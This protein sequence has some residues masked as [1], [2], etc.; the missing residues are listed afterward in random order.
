MT[1]HIGPVGPEHAGEIMT[2]QRAA[3]L[4]E[5]QAHDVLDLPPL[6]ETLDQIKASLEL[7]FGAWLGPRLVGSIRGRVE[8]TRMQ[9]A[10]LS[11]APDMQ[12]QGIGKALLNALT[13][14]RPDNVDTLWLIIGTRS[15]GN[16]RM[17]GNAGFVQT[18]T[19]VDEMNVPIVFMEKK[20]I[21]R[22]G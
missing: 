14:G 22:S 10:R 1:V 3:Y 18:K 7:A 21:S 20:V 9:I 17:Y 6:A 13:E 16:I 12:G 2:V 4:T 15:F 19:G 5:A 11:V 8:G